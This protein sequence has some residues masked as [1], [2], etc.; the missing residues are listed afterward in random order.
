ML[1][2]KCVAPVAIILMV[3]IS[4]VSSAQKQPEIRITEV[5]LRGAGGPEQLATI[6]GSVAR[7][8]PWHELIMPAKRS[9]CMCVRTSG[10]CSH[11]PTPRIHK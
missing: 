2:R 3:L 10:T 5:P 4:I 11:T 8:D 1:S 7:L 9:C 6:A